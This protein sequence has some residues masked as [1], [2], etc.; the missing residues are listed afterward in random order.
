M[1][2][3]LNAF[4]DNSAENSSCRSVYSG[5]LANVMFQDC[6]GSGESQ[7]QSHSLQ[8]DSVVAQRL[9]K[10]SSSS[11][12]E[13]CNSGIDQAAESRAVMTRDGMW[14]KGSERHSEGMCK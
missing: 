4:P 2:G 1:G 7:S 12:K 14:S 13:G 5:Q 3:S 6:S 10:D 8:S 9:S 11:N